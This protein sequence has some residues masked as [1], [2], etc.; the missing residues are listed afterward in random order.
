MKKLFVILILFIFFAFPA[1]A[2]DCPFGYINDPFPGNCSRY[3]DEDGNNICDN[4]QVLAFKDAI[5]QLEQDYV[6]NV[7]QTGSSNKGYYFWQIVVLLLV[8]YG[9]TEYLV[10][11]VKETK[12]KYLRYITK[13]NINRFWNCV[14]LIS[15]LVS[16]LTGMFRIFH[17][18][19]YLQTSYKVVDLHVY[20]SI[21]LLV[22]GLIHILKHWRYFISIIKK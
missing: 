4:G 11:L 10:L 19:G 8:I 20:F 22:V 6:D 1:K 9:F 12:I 14:L 17:M 21:I 16:A 7:A 5:N 3:V 13:T 2:Y 18:L 15:F